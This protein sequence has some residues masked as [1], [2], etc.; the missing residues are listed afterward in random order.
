MLDNVPR[1]VPASPLRGLP[2]QVTG[3]AGFGA[4]AATARERCV[5]GKGATA[6]PRPGYGVDA[7]GPAREST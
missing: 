2:R 7:L 1:F 4:E 6:G 5:S 3:L